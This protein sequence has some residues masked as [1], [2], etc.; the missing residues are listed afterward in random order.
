MSAMV[1]KPKNIGTAAETAV[2]RAIANM[3][4]P[5][6]ERR[7]LKG[8]QDQGDIT[9][10]PGVCWEVKGGDAAKTASDLQIEAWMGETEVE[11][12]NARAAI[13]V[14][15]QQRKGV[16]YANADRWWAWLWSDAL[17]IPFMTG[18]AF[19][20]R[21]RLDDACR[22]LVSQGFGTRPVEAL[23]VPA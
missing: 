6:A 17:E 11:R 9:G 18:Q 22:W 7:A 12:A 3:G 2:V 5:H 13:G 8:T 20:V 14:L 1:N 21:L 16:G 23:E 4:F 10:T 15:V 19:P